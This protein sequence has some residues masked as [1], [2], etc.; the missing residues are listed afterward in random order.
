M[1]STEKPHSTH[2]NSP[3]RRV[4]SVGC[5]EGYRSMGRGIK[6]TCSKILDKE[7]GTGFDRPL[8]RSAIISQGNEKFLVW[9]KKLI[10]NNLNSYFGQ[11]RQIHNTSHIETTTV[12]GI[13][14]AHRLH[15]P[16]NR[17][18]GMHSRTIITS[19][20]W[21]PSMFSIIAPRS[22]TTSPSVPTCYPSP[23]RSHSP[24]GLCPDNTLP[25]TPTAR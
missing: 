16:K 20:A 1:Y 17:C 19:K 14:S 23:S 8:I 3:A 22:T 5:F 21:R 18:H 24:L 12:Q 11:H 6:P 13:H 9:T 2:S 4:S 7:R 25:P 15:G 10:S